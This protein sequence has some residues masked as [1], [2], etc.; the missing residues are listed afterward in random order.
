MRGS[1]R[2]VLTDP[3][4]YVAYQKAMGTRRSRY[5]CL[6]EAGLKPGERVLDVGC[7]PAYYLG[8]LPDVDYVGFDTCEAYVAYARRHNHGRRDFRCEFLTA[9]SLVELGKF[10]AVLLFGLLHH[11]DDAECASLLDLCARALAPGGR[12][13]S[14]DPTLHAG[15][16]RVSRW[17]VE[18]DRGAYVRRPEDYDG[19]ARN[20]FGRVEGRVDDTQIRIPLAQYIMLMT[21][22]LVPGA[23]PV[24]IES[25]V[26][27]EGRR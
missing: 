19:M 18:H 26:R 1:L 8:R 14:A 25:Q 16:G 22:P 5:L 2:S 10:D 21:E 6:G 27:E 13:I 3:R 24:R 17:M 23:G 11:I 7:G 15:Q 9:E 4:V 12:V 20:R